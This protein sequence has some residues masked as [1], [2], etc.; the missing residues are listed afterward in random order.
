MTNKPLTPGRSLP[1]IFCIHVHSGPIYWGGGITLQKRLEGDGILHVKSLKILY[2]MV[3][4]MQ[5]CF[6]IL[7]SPILHVN[8]LQNLP[9]MNLL[10][11]IFYRTLFYDFRPVISP[12]P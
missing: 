7:K 2:V 5:T 10:D 1:L 6:I 9:T 8:V 12:S 3:F 4:D 11:P